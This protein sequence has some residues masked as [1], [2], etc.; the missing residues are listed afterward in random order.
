MYLQTY[1][2]DTPKQFKDPRNMKFGT[3][4]SEKMGFFFFEQFII[5]TENIRL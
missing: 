5:F 3:F 2:L 4:S 1:S